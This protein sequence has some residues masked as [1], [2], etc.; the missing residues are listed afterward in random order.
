MAVASTTMTGPMSLVSS[1]CTVPFPSNA[2][3]LIRQ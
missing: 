1:N 2:V 3:T